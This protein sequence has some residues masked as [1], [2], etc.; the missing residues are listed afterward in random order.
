MGLRLEVNLGQV[1]WA[2]LD[3][4]LVQS[5]SQKPPTSVTPMSILED[6]S[7]FFPDR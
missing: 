1:L 5:K 6:N 3:F 7:L 4:S 2:G